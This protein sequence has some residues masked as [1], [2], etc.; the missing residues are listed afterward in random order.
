MSDL[1]V[2]YFTFARMTKPQQAH[3]KY[4]LERGDIDLEDVRCV[5]VDEETGE[6]VGAVVYIRSPRIEVLE[7]GDAF[8]INVR[9]LG[10]EERVRAIYGDDEWIHRWA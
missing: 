3:I 1:L 10:D 4:M 5:V 7:D 8:K 9:V 6:F 2:D